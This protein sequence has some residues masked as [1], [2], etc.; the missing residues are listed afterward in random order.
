MWKRLIFTAEALR[1]GGKPG[2]AKLNRKGRQGRKESRAGSR[3]LFL[4]VPC[5]FAVNWAPVIGQPGIFTMEARRTAR[6]AKLNE[7]KQQGCGFELLAETR[8]ARAQRVH[9][10]V[11]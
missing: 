9:A 1:L 2:N 5:G 6:N 7:G 3:V 10:D 11:L 8:L 4:R